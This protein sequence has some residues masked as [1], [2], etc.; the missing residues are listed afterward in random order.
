MSRPVHIDA[1]TGLQGTTRAR[2]IDIETEA[3]SH[4]WSLSDFDFM[5]ANPQAVNLALWRG[6]ELAGYAMGLVESGDLHVVSLAVVEAHRRAGWGTRLVE[7]LMRRAASRG[8]R[9]CRLE[10]RRSNRAAQALYKRCGFGA[11]GVAPGY[12]THPAEDALLLERPID[13]AVSVPVP[14]AA[15]MSESPGPNSR[16]PAAT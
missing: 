1:L 16:F 2:L 9:L 10:V 11:A 5:M 8:C 14:T 15:E 6:E 4:P 7:E 12:Y 3:F 13:R